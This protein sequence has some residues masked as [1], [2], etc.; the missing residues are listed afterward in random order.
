MSASKLFSVFSK[1]FL[2]AP[3]SISYF[4]VQYLGLSA[5]IKPAIA[6]NHSPLSYGRRKL[7]MTVT[8]SYGLQNIFRSLKYFSIFGITFQMYFIHLQTPEMEFISQTEP[9]RFCLS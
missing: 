5:R 9:K 3:K 8:L 4:L 6:F 1:N 7:A 2:G